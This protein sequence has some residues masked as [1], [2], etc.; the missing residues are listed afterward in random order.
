MQALVLHHLT[1][2]DLPP[3]WAQRLPSGQRFTITITAEKPRQSKIE[4][5]EDLPPLFGIWKDYA[6]TKDVDAYVRNLRKGR[7]HAD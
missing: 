6:A 1:A 5:T 4:E 2:A 7:F 3:E